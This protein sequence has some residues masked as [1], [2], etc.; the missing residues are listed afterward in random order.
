[1]AGLDLTPALIEAEYHRLGHR[2]GWRFLTSPERTLDTATVALVT[3]NPSGRVDDTTNPRWS[4]ETG[5]AYLTEGWRGKAVGRNPLQVQVQL[6]FQAMGVDI[7]SAL[8]GYFIP[9]RSPRLTSL[10]NQRQSFDF[11]KKLWSVVFARS[12]ATTVI[13]FGYPI[14]QEICGILAATERKDCLAH[15]GA[16]TIRSYICRDNRLLFI[17][18]HLSQFK[19]FSRP[20]SEAAFRALLRERRDDV[21]HG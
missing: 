1:M 18:P 12:P 4:V 15:W 10:T 16:L 8:S 6:L 9:F 21:A 2:I 13:A 17:L 5:N 19:L 11:G 20:A 7:R 3:A 14:E